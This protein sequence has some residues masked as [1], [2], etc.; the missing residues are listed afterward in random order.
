VGQD[1]ALTRLAQN[2]NVEVRVFNPFPSGR[3]RIATRFITS[4]FDMRRISRRMHNKLCVA[5]NAVAI[6]GG[7][8]LGSRYFVRNPTNNFL[9]LD[10]FI[11]GPAVRQLSVAFDRYWNSDLAYPIESLSTAR[12]NAL[13]DGLA[14]APP[15]VSNASARPS[16]E[17]PPRSDP[18]PSGPA[19]AELFSGE[20]AGAEISRPLKN[21]FDGLLWTD[22]AVLVDAPS[23]IVNSKERLD[24]DE[25]LADNVGR[26]LKMAK[27]E[28]IIVTPYLVPG[29]KG[30]R[31]LGDARRRGVKI[32]ILTNSFAS[33]DEPIVHIG[34]SRYRPQ[35]LKLGVELYEMQPMLQRDQ[36]RFG[37]FGSSQSTLHAKAMIIDRRIL[38]I[39][40]MNFDPRSALLNTEMAVVVTSPVMAREVARLFGETARASSFRL[41][42]NGDGNRVLWTT[43]NGNGVTTDVEPQTTFL[44]RLGMRLIAPFVPDE[45]L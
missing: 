30:I 14:Q 18:P 33:V 25:T 8:N 35:L 16:P 42:L 24:P 44:K 22:S 41:S 26:L 21:L 15:P 6:T 1:D 11:A 37:R 34:Y 9:D 13:P 39:G 4:A 17:R 38:F 20:S 2:P 7:R 29:E 40:S 19:E 23:K 45:Q 12:S 27:E 36:V 10:F 5:D 32:R 28:I 31:V 3:A 43:A